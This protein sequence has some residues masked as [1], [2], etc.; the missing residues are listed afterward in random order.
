[1]RV[2]IYA[3]FSSTVQREASI[4]DQC[5]RAEAR[6]AQEGWAVVARYSD[7]ALSGS[8]A[9]RPGYQAM[10]AAASAREFEILLVEDLSRLSRDQVESE[11]A[12]RRLE[13]HGLRIVGCADGYDS[14]SKARKVHRGIKGLMNEI[15]LDDLADKT[16]RGLEGQALKGLHTGGKAYGYRLVHVTDPARRDAHGQPAVLGSR[17]E[18]DPEQAEWVRWIFARYAD[19][20]SARAIADELNKCQVTSPGAAWNRRTPRRARWL[21][22]A[23]AGPTDGSGILNNPAYRGQLVWNRTTWVRDPDTGK[24]RPVARPQSEWVVVAA[25]ELRIV[26][27]AL[28]EAVKRRQRAQSDTVGELVK[29]GLSR[30]RARRRG[31]G[32]KFLFSGLLTC[33]CCGSRYVV[34]NAVAYGCA[35]HANGGAH[36][37][38]NRLRVRRDVVE[39]RLLAGIREGLLAPARVELFQA[40]VR[41]LLAAQA[42][43]AAAP[44]APARLAELRTEIGHLTDAIAAGLLKSSPALAARLRAAEAEL[45]RL[46]AEQARPRGED[47]VLRTLPRVAEIYREL[48]DDLGAAVIDDMPRARHELR[49]LVGDEIRLVKAQDGDYLEA[50]IAGGPA[51]LLGA[52]CNSLNINEKNNLVA[53]AGFEPTTFGL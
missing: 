36:A 50:E 49:K 39:S 10:L 11:R 26:S 31:R 42:K 16:R 43:A 14:Q 21:S 40:E 22:T 23:I 34:V 32:P 13:F 6:A 7:E 2:A 4:S 53:G 46:Q 47:K 15:Y 52:S 45:A 33:G 19:G 41:R 1:V 8:R 35:S 12:I 18:I 20:W 37:C 29:A 5:R 3:R 30:D 24:R 51:A 9:D 25:P 38:A 28:W 27:D 48:I 44:T 17:R